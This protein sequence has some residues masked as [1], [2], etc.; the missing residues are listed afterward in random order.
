[1]SRISDNQQHY[2]LPGMSAVAVSL[3]VL[4]VSSVGNG[5]YIVDE[6]DAERK[7]KQSH[8]RFRARV[9]QRACEWSKMF[10]SKP[11]FHLSTCPS[12]HMPAWMCTKAWVRSSAPFHAPC[13]ATVHVAH[14]ISSESGRLAT[15]KDERDR[16]EVSSCRGGIWRNFARPAR[17]GGCCH[18][19]R[20]ARE[21]Y[22]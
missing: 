14:N 20:R 18:G 7:K 21:V 4:R 22:G 12:V 17:C 10:D 2:S 9:Q 11:C 16:P 15:T 13:P 5:D 6:L 8:L 1:M 3:R 19:N